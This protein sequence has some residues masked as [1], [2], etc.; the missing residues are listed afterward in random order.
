MKNKFLLTT[1]LL[2]S[3]QIVAQSKLERDK[4]VDYYKKNVI[5]KER[6]DYDKYSYLSYRKDLIKCAQLDIPTKIITSDGNEGHFIRFDSEIPLYYTTYNLGSAITSRA[7]LVQPGGILGLN[8]AGSGMIVGVWDQNH[9]RTNHADYGTRISITDGS[10]VAV[11]NHS[12]HVTGTILS[13]GSNN[14][15]GRGIAYQAQG[16]IN[17]WTNDIGEM[18]QYS[19]FGLLLSNHSYGLIATSLPTWY[20]GAYV[21]DSR[22]VDLVCFNSPKYLPVYAAGNDR[23]NF[24]NIN[25][26]K[27]G[28]DLLTGDKTAK[29]AL[30]IGAVNNVS[31]YTG[32][33][34]VVMSNFSN[35]GPTDDFRIK[36]DLVTKGVNVFSTTSA[37]TNSYGFLSGTSM[38]AP[39]VTGGLLL[40]QQYFGS[41]YMNS[42][43]LRG[44]VIHTADDAG[45]SSG[46][47]HMF[48]WG[49]INIGKSAQV[50][51]DRGSNSL[52]EE[53]TLQN[54]QTYS[55]LVLANNIEDVK[56]TLTW[57]DRPGTALNNSADNNSP[58]LINDLDLRVRKNNDTFFPW[59]LNKDFNNLFALKGDNNVDNVE[60][61]DLENTSGIYEIIVSHKGSLVGGL[62]NYSLIITGIDADAILDVENYKTSNNLFWKKGE[63]LY[64]TLDDGFENGDHVEIFDLNGR[65]ILKNKID[66]KNGQINVS[67]FSKGVYL[68]KVT[69]LTKSLVVVKKIIF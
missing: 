9:P 52:V 45:S 41:P 44:L 55:K 43:T 5:L 14:S 40:L 49:L 30:V 37:S 60:R 15:E 39:G 51:I 16:W 29:N 63:N 6:F 46:P 28:N 27:N 21:S 24:T 36:P 13:S 47:D 10:A 68:V 1:L 48:G 19:A 65:S 8:L 4:I 59:R 64:Y 50:L 56:V 32:P 62:Q 34:D 66:T 69:G 2:L 67:Q 54:N 25:P 17:D 12:T 61:V 20:F 58:R 31:N 35:Y 18:E 38:A 22:A 33:S 7:N 42:S 57:T 26:S 53:N 11:S 3:L 23:D